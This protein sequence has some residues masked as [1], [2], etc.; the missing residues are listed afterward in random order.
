MLTTDANGIIL[1]YGSTIGGVSPYAY[2]SPSAL[3]M[4]QGAG[5]FYGK[6]SAGYA[7]S[8]LPSKLDVWGSK[9]EMVRRVYTQN[10][11]LDD[12]CLFVYDTSNATGCTGTPSTNCSSYGT[13]Q[14]NC[15]AHA[16]V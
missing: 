14:S 4:T 2:I 9:M 10:Y 1:E 8:N 7:Y 3:R 13:N 12:D 15:D 6:V 5:Q 16:E 11:T